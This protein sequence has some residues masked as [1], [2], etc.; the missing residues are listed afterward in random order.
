MLSDSAYFCNFS[1]G[2]RRSSGLVMASLS[3]YAEKLG[4]KHQDTTEGHILVL[5]FYEIFFLKEH[6]ISDCTF[7]NSRTWTLQTHLKEG[8]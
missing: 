4:E 8:T 5:N 3:L 7:L 1:I 2:G 6:N